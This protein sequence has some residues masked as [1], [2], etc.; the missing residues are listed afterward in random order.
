MSQPIS[1]IVTD[2]TGRPPL[3]SLSLLHRLLAVALSSMVFAMMV[4]RPPVYVGCPA[5]L[6]GLSR[7]ACSAT[8]TVP[9]FTMCPHATPAKQCVEVARGGEGTQCQIWLGRIVSSVDQNPSD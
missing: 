5:N 1:A 7:A 8:A 9:H 6:S 3:T 4:W 2:T